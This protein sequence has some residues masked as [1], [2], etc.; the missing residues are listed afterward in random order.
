M[1][2]KLFPFPFEGLMFMT[3]FIIAYSH[4]TLAVVGYWATSWFAYARVINRKSNVLSWIYGCSAWIA[5]MQPF[6]NALNDAT[7]RLILR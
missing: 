5:A 3:A 2:P 1:K 4:P 7:V 6:A